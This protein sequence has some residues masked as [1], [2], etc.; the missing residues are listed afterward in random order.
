MGTASDGRQTDLSGRLRAT[1][2]AVQR[3]ARPPPQRPPRRDVLPFFGGRAAAGG[4][5][6]RARHFAFFVR[7]RERVFR[8][9]RSR[10]HGV[11]FAA[12]FH[13]DCTD[14]G[15]VSFRNRNRFFEFV[16]LRGRETGIGTVVFGRVRLR[17][18]LSRTSK[19]LRRS[20]VGL[21]LL[22]QERGNRD[23][24]Q[25]ADDHH[26]EQQLDEGETTLIGATTTKLG[27]DGVS[28]CELWGYGTVGR[29]AC[30]AR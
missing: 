22:V 29:R 10:G 14:P 26:Y 8:A 20:V 30:P 4:P 9:G 16:Q 6:A 27:G 3:P 24:G 15:V 25:D 2:S 19:L 17:R 18:R 28:S 12:F 21:A 1:A 5:R 23:R 11:T 13:C 7:D